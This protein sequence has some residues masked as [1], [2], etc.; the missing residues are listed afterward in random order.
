V[1]IHSGADDES[2]A[3]LGACRE[4]LGVLGVSTEALLWS[5]QG[6][7][8]L[9]RECPECEGLDMIQGARGRM[10]MGA[11]VIGW[12]LWEEAG[13]TDISKTE[14]TRRVP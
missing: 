9:P 1:R 2:N 4:W 6:I 8:N 11:Q 3:R 7:G 12:V 13:I 10:R 14:K 5:F